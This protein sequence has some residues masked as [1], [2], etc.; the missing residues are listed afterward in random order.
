M[1]SKI[2][3]YRED[4]KKY[5]MPALQHQYFG[6]GSLVMERAN[7]E[8]MYDLGLLQWYLGYELWTLQP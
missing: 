4:A 8:Y 3:R 2:Q 1:N 7:M 6:D 5:L